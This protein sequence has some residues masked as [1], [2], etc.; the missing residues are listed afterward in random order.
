[1]ELWNLSERYR[2]IATSSRIAC[3]TDT[4]I[5]LRGLKNDSTCI[6]CVD[7]C[8]RERRMRICRD[9]LT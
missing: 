2:I 3:V 1:M 9:T 7:S 6:V 8:D 4:H 5:G